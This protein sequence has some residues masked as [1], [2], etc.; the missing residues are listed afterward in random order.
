SD[1]SEPAEG[2]LLPRLLLMGSWPSYPGDRHG[3]RRRAG[4][5]PRPG[6]ARRGPLIVSARP[7]RGAQ[8]KTPTSWRRGD[9]TGADSTGGPSM[10]P[11]CP[12]PEPELA[13]D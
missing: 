13:T 5:E 7:T 12:H 9:P 1:D 6:L 2:T 11:R 10:W 8:S 3:R 4:L